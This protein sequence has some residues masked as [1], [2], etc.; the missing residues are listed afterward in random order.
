[1]DRK[2]SLGD[3]WETPKR[4]P[5]HPGTQQ[6]AGICRKVECLEQRH[7]EGVG[8]MSTQRAGRR[9]WLPAGVVPHWSGLLKHASLVFENKAFHQFKIRANSRIRANSVF[10]FARIQEF[11]RMG[12]NN[13][14]EWTRQKADLQMFEKGNENTVLPRKC[15]VQAVMIRGGGTKQ[16]NRTVLA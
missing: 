14:R 4:G 8:P 10:E 9:P 12:E 3:R 7:E 6:N 16:V 11:A 2:E 15:G 5:Q 13:S 1:M